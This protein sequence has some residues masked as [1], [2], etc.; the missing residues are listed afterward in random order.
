MTAGL[1]L[2]AALSAQHSPCARLQKLVSGSSLAFGSESLRQI[3]QG[4]CVLFSDLQ[5]GP[6]LNPII[7]MSGKEKDDDHDQDSLKKAF[8][9]IWSWSSENLF[10]EKKRR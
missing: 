9:H 8:W 5:N 2:N 10:L 1:L 6:H 3:W 7:R 4:C